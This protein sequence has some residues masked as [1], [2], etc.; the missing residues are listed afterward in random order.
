MF[1]QS[2]IKT[3]SKRLTS[4]ST[5][6]PVFTIIFLGFNVQLFKCSCFLSGRAWKD[7]LWPLTFWSV[8]LHLP[9]RP[10]C[11]YLC[12]MCHTSTCC[13]CELTLHSLLSTAQKCG[14][15]CIFYW[16]YFFLFYTYWWVT[17]LHPKRPSWLWLSVTMTLA[18][19]VI[20]IQGVW[21]DS[22]SRNETPTKGVQSLRVAPSL[23]YEVS[24][25]MLATE[26]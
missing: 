26:C 18:R 12:E 24:R 20:C 8:L 16:F 10:H 5:L 19:L 15:K 4:H 22:Q 3:H 14:L 7:G 11:Q 23:Q 2:S 6:P 9:T 25:G 21:N 17:L 1:L 13:R